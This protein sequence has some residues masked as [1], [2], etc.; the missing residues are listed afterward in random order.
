MGK[1]RAAVRGDNSLIADASVRTRG[2]IA[3]ELVSGL[4]VLMLPATDLESYVE[5]VAEDNPLL[6]VNFSSD[7]FG[8]ERLP[9][10]GQSEP[11]EANHD[12]S[13][14]EDGRLMAAGSTE[15]D[16]SRIEDDYIETETLH[17]F[18]RIQSLGLNLSRGDQYAM[19]LLIESVSDDGYFSGS[20]E[21]IVFESGCSL[22]R[23]SNLLAMMRKMQPVGVAQDNLQECL[24]SQVGG[25]IEH[26]DMIVDMIRTHLYDV[27]EGRICAL[28]REYGVSQGRIIQ[29]VSVIRSLDPR[30]G[31]SFFRR[32]EYQYVMPDIVIH[33]GL[34]GL[35]VFVSGAEVP[36]LTLNEDYLGLLDSDGL[37]E[38][39]RAY[40]KSRCDEARAVLRF[41]DARNSL[42]KKFA[43]YLV[44]RQADYFLT[45]GRSLAPMT[46]RDVGSALGVHVSTISRMVQ[47]KYLKT[48]WCCIPIKTL[49][50]SSV[51]RAEGGLQS[52]SVSSEGV[53]RM[54]RA[55]VAS[56][57]LGRP[58]T[59]AM[60]CNILNEQGVAI[61]RR[62]VAKYRDACGIPTQSK[63]KWATKIE[64]E[65][66]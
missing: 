23:T 57:P 50:T 24:A 55:L 3:P 45:E 22:E 40:I 25:S 59:D 48:D 31:A 34:N 37:T 19:D 26:A 11:N 21:Q 52:G 5:S 17:S 47:G 33:R 54:I 16:F 7:I 36:C 43:L 2:R 32:P 9:L 63:R 4:R 66:Q 61:K 58:Y 49:F 13:P 42:L 60:L 1:I 30:P 56:E 65:A 62:T 41:L 64:K 14:M 35:E 18:L 39:S 53:K 10:E 8:F 28:A 51:P 27:A 38:E 6:E 15:W 44:K 29:A 46:M 12:G 20:V